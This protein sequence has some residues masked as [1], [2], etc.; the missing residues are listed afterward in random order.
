MEHNQ[1]TMYEQHQQQI[2]QNQ[3]TQNI[4]LLQ[5]Q[6]QQQQQSHYLKKTQ[7]QHVEPKTKI[8][9]YT[10][11]I[12]ILESLKTI[13]MIFSDYVQQNI[14]KKHTKLIFLYAK[15]QAN[16]KETHFLIYLTMFIQK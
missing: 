13:Y 15:E 14:F 4:Q 1:Q 9:L 2:Q 3:H 7:Q 8:D 5:Q 10:Q 11:E 6:Q 12:S 16:L